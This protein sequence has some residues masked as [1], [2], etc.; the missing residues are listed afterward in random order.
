MGINITFQK[1]SPVQHLQKPTEME[2]GLPERDIDVPWVD[3]VHD[4]T[5]ST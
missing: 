4:I 1:V 2:D 3:K 5:Y